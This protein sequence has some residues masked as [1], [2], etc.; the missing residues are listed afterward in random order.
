M[1]RHKAVRV[2]RSMDDLLATITTYL[3]DPSLDRE[4]RAAMVREICGPLDGHASDRIADDL[5]KF[6][7]WRAG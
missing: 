1:L 3:Q 7:E 2:V 6:R 4:G 5:L